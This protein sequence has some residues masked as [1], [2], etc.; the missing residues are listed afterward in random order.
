MNEALENF[1][2]LVQDCHVSWFEGTYD[3][4][5]HVP[6]LFLD[7]AKKIDFPFPS[8][9]ELQRLYDIAQPASFGRGSEAVL[10][11]TY[12]SARTL[13]TEMFAIN[14][15]PDRRLLDQIEQLMFTEGD[16]ES[17]V[18]VQA[19]LYRVNIYGPGDFFKEH[20][21]TPQ[22]GTG[23]FGSLVFCLPT[24]F[25][26]GAF[27]LRDPQGQEVRFDWA[28]KF[29]E[30]RSPVAVA[31]EVSAH[32]ES[33]AAQ[34][35]AIPFLAFASD[36]DHW[37]EPVTSGYRVTVTFHLFR[38]VVS[39]KHI[40]REPFMKQFASREEM[41]AMRNL[42]TSKQLAGK[43]ILF[44][45]V[46]QYSGRANYEIVLK[47][48]DGA[49]F[50]A[51]TDLGAKP[52]IKFYYKDNASDRYRYDDDGDD[53]DG[54]VC[55]LTDVVEMYSEK[56]LYDSDDNPLDDFGTRSRVTW[57]RHDR[58]PAL[59]LSVGGSYGNQPSM[60]EYNG[61]VCIVAKF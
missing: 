60:Q 9:A 39:K 45:L 22:P 59:M 20:K 13:T 23:H 16:A 49:L 1:A 58:R 2:K 6:S 26:G 17:S 29:A 3:A 53:G 30:T 14:L 47:G 35:S 19:V 44:P 28:S 46:H 55:Y 52:K 36:L 27:M 38:E 61:N 34:P 31:T 25:E 41:V 5:A 4:L 10:D 21:D 57:A 54:E 50:Q 8:Q 37:I 11:P 15:K 40:N 33:A 32:T 43:Q 18:H 24:D 51:L 42:V 7:N 12:R 56:G 48:G